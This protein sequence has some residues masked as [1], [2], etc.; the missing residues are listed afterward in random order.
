V[1][2]TDK[3]GSAFG[4]EI[5]VSCLQ[6]GNRFRKS[7]RCAHDG[8]QA[9]ARSSRFDHGSGTPL[10]ADGISAVEDQVPGFLWVALPTTASLTVTDDIL[11]L[12]PVC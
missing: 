8:V 2:G 5:E 4:Y 7:D 1:L 9:A 11:G 6:G 3:A 12:P 10:R